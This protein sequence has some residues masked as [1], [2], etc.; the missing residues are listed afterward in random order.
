VN[1][2]NE[3]APARA[4]SA[5]EIAAVSG[6]SGLIWSGGGRKEDDG[7]GTLGSGT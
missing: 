6:G 4:L 3:A 2:R 1:E 7:G 5:E